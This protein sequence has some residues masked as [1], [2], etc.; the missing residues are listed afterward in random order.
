MTKIIMI[1]MKLKTNLYIYTSFAEFCP[2]FRKRRTTIKTKSRPGDGSGFFASTNDLKQASRIWIT[3]AAT[4][5]QIIKIAS[6]KSIL[7]ISGSNKKPR[8]ITFAGQTL[9][10]CFLSTAVKYNRSSNDMENLI[11]N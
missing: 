8:W 6:F 10:L 9:Q 11:I 4:L 3:E 5:M 2:V 7:T 1:A